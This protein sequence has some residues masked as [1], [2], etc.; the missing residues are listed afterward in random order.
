M[1]E[2]YRK[3]TDSALT[4][5]AQAILTKGGTTTPLTFPDGFTS[6]I[7]AIDTALPTTPL[8]VTPRV[9][10]QVFDPPSGYNY[11]RVTVEEIPSITVSNLSGGETVTIG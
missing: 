8:S 5:V 2:V 11:G 3:V 1:P 6:A 10:Q 7:E 9:Q 4:S